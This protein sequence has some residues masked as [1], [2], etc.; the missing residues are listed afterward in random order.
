MNKKWKN[1][2]NKKIIK[3]IIKKITINNQILW[4]QKF[5]I[6]KLIKIIWMNKNKVKMKKIKNLYS[7]N[8]NTQI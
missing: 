8:N 7:N 1:N 2:N 5:Q 6:K 4:I 3:T